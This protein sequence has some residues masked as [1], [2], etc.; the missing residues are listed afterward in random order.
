[1]QIIPPILHASSAF[2]V[3][4]LT[5]SSARN[6]LETIHQV[7]QHRHHQQYLLTQ[8][9]RINSSYN[10]AA[11]DIHHPQ[12][13]PQQIDL[14]GSIQSTN[15]PLPS[16]AMDALAALRQWKRKELVKLFLECPATPP[17]HWETLIEGEWNGELLDNNAVLVCNRS[18]QF[19]Q[20]MLLL[21]CSFLP[22]FIF[23][24]GTSLLVP[25][26]KGDILSC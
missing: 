9:G 20:S 22:F 17:S 11:N 23:R 15:P 19:W 25:F 7:R 10:N 12:Q 13:L 3:A 18:P 26:S 2:A 24:F 8:I 14:H 6:I 5:L 1:M 16:S 21:A 4:V